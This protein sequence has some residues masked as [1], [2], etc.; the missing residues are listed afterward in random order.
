[1]IFEAN[2]VD[3]VSSVTQVVTFMRAEWKLDG[4]LTGMPVRAS[5]I[6]RAVAEWTIVLMLCG[7]GEA[8]WRTG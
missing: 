5:G 7:S 6:W 1:M 4:A 8:A 2:S 3:C